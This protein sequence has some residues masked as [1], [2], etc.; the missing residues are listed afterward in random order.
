LRRP[1][2]RFG[3]VKVA[4]RKICTALS[5]TNLNSGPVRFYGFVTPFG[6]AKIPAPPPDFSAVTLVNYANTA[7]KARRC[8][9]GRCP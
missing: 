9:S 7:A 8:R 3:I 4:L 6:T 1:P 2:R 5:I